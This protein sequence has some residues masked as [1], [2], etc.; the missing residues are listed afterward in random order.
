MYLGDR[1]RLGGAE[2]DIS[3]SVWTLTAGPRPETTTL[4]ATET[5]DVLVIGGGFNGVTAGLHCAE[6][7]AKVILV[8]AGEI[9]CGASGRNAGMVNPGQFISPSRILAALGP[10]YGPRFL[11]DLGGAPDI[12]RGLIETHGIACFADERP[13]I[14]CATSPAMIRE[15]ETQARDWRALG[16]DV[17]MVHGEE[18][19]RMNGSARYAAA[20]MDHRGF[21]LQ[22]LAYA[23][24]LARAAV[25]RGL[26][27]ACGVP[28]SALEPSG[29]RWVAAAGA[30]RITA[31]KV[32]LSTN[33]YSGDLVPGFKEEFMPLGAFTIATRDPIPAEWRERILPG[34]VAMWD[35]HA[36]PLWFRYDPENR[37]QVGSIGFLP[38]R[39]DRDGWARRAVRFVFPDAPDF[40]WGYRW[41]GIVGHTRSQLPHLVEPRPGIYATVGCNGRGIAPNAYFGKLLARMA[42]GE[43]VEAPLPLRTSTPHPARRLSMEAYDL[44]TRIYRNTLLFR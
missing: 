26:R 4:S 5:C 30:S 18:L 9:G 10:E 35:T 8:E 32:I 19:R 17:R 6:R 33:A 44:G 7:G 43:A 3:N 38:W 27:I 39:A 1:P 21:T 31:D 22:P 25:A 37:L 40:E 23:R 11:R 2:P 14:R 20:L 24:G 15:L 36:I 29:S 42:L 34:S 41:S 13:I 28:V 16:A 12:V